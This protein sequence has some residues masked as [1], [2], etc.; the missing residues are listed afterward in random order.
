META[1]NMEDYGRFLFLLMQGLMIQFVHGVYGNRK[2]LQPV[3]VSV[4]RCFL[5]SSSHLV[6]VLHVLPAGMHDLNQYMISCDLL[7]VWRLA[8]FAAVH[9]A[10]AQAHSSRGSIGS[11]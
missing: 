1:C 5:L 11:W 10:I 6:G 3:V 7:G 8:T 9:E 4:S 2:T